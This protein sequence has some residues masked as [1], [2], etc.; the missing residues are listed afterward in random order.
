MTKRILIAAA[1]VAALAGG[2]ALASAQGP[3]GGFGIQGP[4]G[5]MRGVPAG[6]LGLRG[7]QLTDAQREQ[8]RSIRESHQA[9]IT[10]AVRK[11]RDA[12][13]AFAEASRSA[14]VD[15]GAIRTRSTDLA[16][17]MAEEAIVRARLRAEVHALLTPEQQQQ[18]RDR[19]A[20]MQRRM[21]E[22]QKQM[23]ERQPRQRQPRPQRPPQ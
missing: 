23:Q 22:R 10:E 15:E 17:A 6:D 7:I 4:R 3:R 18:L 13:R 21:Q 16:S 19:E 2:T 8:V 1:L 12:Q 20:Q 11:L 14:P 5:P 9:E